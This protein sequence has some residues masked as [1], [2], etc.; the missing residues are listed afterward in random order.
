MRIVNGVTIT[1]IETVKTANFRSDRG[2]TW[3]SADNMR[4]WGT[5]VGAAVYGER[6]F[7]TSDITWDGTRAYSIRE[8]TDDGSVETVAFQNY[9]SRGQAHRAAKILGTQEI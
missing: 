3:F 4:F 9:G 7:V 1:T 6:Y 2:N 8:L 5:R